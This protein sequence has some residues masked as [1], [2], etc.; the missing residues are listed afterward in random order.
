VQL[1]VGS[2]WTDTHGCEFRID[3]I[4]KNGEE[5]WVAYTRVKDRTSY[6]CLAQAFTYRFNPLVQ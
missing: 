3:A 1:S 6:C 4:D 5:I 2:S